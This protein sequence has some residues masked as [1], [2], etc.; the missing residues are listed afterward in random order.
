MKLAQ[1]NT[2]IVFSSLHQTALKVKGR[3]PTATPE[4][5]EYDSS[6]LVAMD[7]N[8]SILYTSQRGFWPSSINLQ[9]SASQ[10]RRT[11]KMLMVTDWVE[12]FLYSTVILP[13]TGLYFIAAPKG[14]A[15]A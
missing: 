10:V 14:V 12:M 5:I 9:A 1:W 13:E 8:S 6:L 7:L 4:M 15:I 2:S 3:P 11:R